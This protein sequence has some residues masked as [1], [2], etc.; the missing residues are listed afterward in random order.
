MYIIQTVLY[1]YNNMGYCNYTHRTAHYNILL[2]YYTVSA[3]CYI[4]P[5]SRTQDVFINV[6]AYNLWSYLS[7]ILL[8]I[9]FIVTLCYTF[10]VVCTEPYYVYRL[11]IIFGGGPSINLNL[12]ASLWASILA[13]E[14][15]LF[16][17]FLLCVMIYLWCLY[18]L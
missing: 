15:I 8:L 17:I 9:F 11:Y 1:K 14:V 5:K 4:L 7:I 16:Y 3:W 13:I 12:I 18:I 6:F 10:S 2:S